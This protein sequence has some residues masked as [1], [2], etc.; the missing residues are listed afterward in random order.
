MSKFNKI[1]CLVQSCAL[2]AAALILLGASAQAAPRPVAIVEE[3]AKTEGRGQVFDLLTEN[4]TMQLA[5]GETIVLG[6]LKS[7]VRET[8]T[9][10]SVTIGAK[11][12]VVEGGKVA[13]EK[14]ECAVNKLLLTEDQSQQS[15]TIAFRPGDTLKHIYTRQPVIMAG[16]SENVTIQPFE[17]GESWDL[18]PENGRIDFRAAKFEMQP[19]M[20][21]RVTGAKA[22]I[23]VE[24]DAAATT[25]KT[26]TLERVVIL[27]S[28]TSTTN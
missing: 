25:A 10:G 4:D 15:A 8:I 20:R 6:Y 21:Y 26:G 17:G 19:G 24:V 11:E 7:C 23:I 12:S 9:G 13:R 3:S 22:T 2:A 27:D 5:A 16:M 28:G 1:R 18:V 14:T